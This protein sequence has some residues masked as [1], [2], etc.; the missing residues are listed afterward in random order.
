[1]APHNPSLIERVAG[2]QIDPPLENNGGDLVVVS[3]MINFLKMKC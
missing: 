3:D 2:N 1:M